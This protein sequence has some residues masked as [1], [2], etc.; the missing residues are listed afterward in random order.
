M[1]NEAS[2]TTTRDRDWSQVKALATYWIASDENM[3]NHPPQNLND[4]FEED[5]NF[6][7]FTD[8]QTKY[9]MK[10]SSTRSEAL[11]DIKL[12]LEIWRRGKEYSNCADPFD[13]DT[14]YD[15]LVLSVLDDLIRVFKL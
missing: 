3:R 1:S 13:L 5:N 12:K 10:I 15:C 7:N 4:T 8:E 9:A 14:P 2:Q 6:D 11:E